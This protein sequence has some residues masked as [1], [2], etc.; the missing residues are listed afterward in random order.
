[1]DINDIEHDA[2]ALGRSFALKGRGCIYGHLS[3]QPS[4]RGPGWWYVSEIGHHVSATVQTLSGLHKAYD[5]TLKR[6][7]ARAKDRKQPV[8]KPG[9]FTV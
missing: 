8:R 5:S 9:T 7:Q 2:T 1:M 4:G 3:L 6:R